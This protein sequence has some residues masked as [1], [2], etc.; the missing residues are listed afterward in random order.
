MRLTR[1]APLRMLYAWAADMFDRPLRT[2]PASLPP[3][4][5][6]PL[7]FGGGA[8]SSAVKAL[9]FL[10]ACLEGLLAMNKQCG[11]VFTHGL[12]MTARSS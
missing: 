4:W 3:Y 6:P 1:Y 2:L 10:K 11:F 9:D 5:E 8:K 7:I 12:G